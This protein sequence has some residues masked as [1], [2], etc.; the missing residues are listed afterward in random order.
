MKLPNYKKTTKPVEVIIAQENLDLY[1]LSGLG[2][3]L[4][5]IKPDKKRIPI[6]NSRKETPSI[7]IP[8]KEP[9]PETVD[10]R[11]ISQGDYLMP[12]GKSS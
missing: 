11:K 10:P 12:P 6:K 2:A 7:L 4:A 1:V 9:I 5:S 8:I 3:S